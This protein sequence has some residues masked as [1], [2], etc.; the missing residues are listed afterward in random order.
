MTGAGAEHDAPGA[1]SPERPVGGG[2]DG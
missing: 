1:P 2:Q